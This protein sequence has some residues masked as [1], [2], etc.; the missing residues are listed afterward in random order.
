M[1]LSS[2]PTSRI[3]CVRGWLWIAACCGVSVA[4]GETIAL[5]SEDVTFFE[6]K[7]RPIFVAHCA[8][9]HSRMTGETEGGLSF[10]SKADFL[11][12]EGVA[13]AGRPDESLIVK[14]L[15]YDGDPQMPPDGKLPAAA[16]A[17]IEEW[18]RRGLPWPDDGKAAGPVE[19]FD[20]ASRKAAHWC[21]R[22]PMVV[23]TPK[24]EDAQWCRSDIDRFVLARLEAAGIEPAAEASLAVLVRRASEVLTGLPA[25]PADA[26]QVASHP[27]PLAF[28]AFV[29]RLLASPHYGERFARHWLD[30]VRYGETR[31]HE[32]DFLIP[33]VWRYRDWVVEAFNDDLPYDQFVREQIAG[34]LIQDPRID[35]GSG[36]N[37]SVVGT[38]FWFL[39]EEIHSPVDIAQD[40][41]DRIDNKVDTFGK[42]FLGLALGCAR[43]H[44]HKFDAI[45]NEDY[46]AIAGMLMSSSYRQVPLETIALNRRV[47]TQ[48]DAAD[49]D[50]RQKL[51]P[52]VADVI[53]AH[54]D[55]WMQKMPAVAEVVAAWREMDAAATSPAAATPLAG[56]TPLAAQQ[57][58]QEIVLADY[59]RGKNAT[60]VISDSTAWG[61]AARPPG[62]PRLSAATDAAPP[63]ITL[64]ALGAAFSDA[65]WSKSSSTGEREPGSQGAIDRAGRLLRTPKVRITN[66]VL[67]HRVRGHLQIVAVV[68]GHVMVHGPLYGATIKTVDTKGQWEWIQHDL[69]H[70][71]AWDASASQNG[72]VVHVEF[73]AISGEAEVAEVVAAEQQPR[74]VDPLVHFLAQRVGVF[75]SASGDGPVAESQA[76][77]YVQQAA[78][79]LFDMTLQACRSGTLA[80]APD[81]AAMASLVARLLPSSADAIPAAT[82]IAG[83]PRERLLKTAVG[84]V[85]GRNQIAAAATMVS[86]T[87]PA[88]LDGNGI[89]QH[90]LLKGSASR[91][92][93]RVPRR[94]LEAIDGLSQQPW[95]EHSSGRLELADRVLDAA[96][97]LASR[98]IVNRIWHH[99][100][101]RGLVATPDNFGKLGEQ[102]SDTTSQA[103]LDSLAVRFRAEG[104][105]I[106]RLVKEIV[107]SS[108]WRMSSR[109][110]PR[111]AAQ[112]PLNLLLHHYPL[113]RLE[114]EAIHDKILALSGRLDRTIGGPS[115]EVFLTEAHDGRGK[116]P[117]GPLDGGG[118]RSIYTKIRRNFLPSF[119]VA[120]DLPTPFQA[121]GMRNVTN[122]PAQS[123]SLMNDPFVNQQATLWAKKW[124]NDET[125]TTHDRIDRMYRDAFA[126]PPRSD[127]EA[128]AVEFLAA[129]A[130]QHGGTIAAQPWQLAA[131]SDFAHAMI[132]AKEFIFIP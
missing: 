10:D 62:Q 106:K 79:E 73:A 69:R 22:A 90:V 120:F 25:D 84:L 34:D 50:M 44:D 81:A 118:R 6:S 13:V 47:A 95:P 5:R 28:D 122:V 71:R 110:D 39:G 35:P 97:P 27:D 101:G 41:A 85:A 21:W 54:E 86:A 100:F 123:L 78:R 93:E 64:Q 32:S 70:D 129:Q 37:Q 58:G 48:L 96:N 3:T 12:A 83:S 46:Y 42:A 80:D 59:T 119:L 63:A 128:A 40:E 17:T 19:A 91:P 26:E 74:R 82:V 7:V 77:Q 92:G 20:I 56:A 111:A 33:N 72:H 125:L 67:W 1:A 102:P 109:R 65:V 113:R 116:P 11:T 117:S 121:M 30:V 24:V 2:V 114:A 53:A 31:G 126:R 98:V 15:R 51:L 112:D 68:D 94:F 89:D 49:A 66:G 60:A 52:L 29:D 18:V 76:R 43:C 108:T 8:K 131:W 55:V 16:I 23:P 61:L 75:A 104:W 36:A 4:S 103:I 14:V 107:T 45:S 127:E 130:Q 88:I 38:G 132:N 105:S 115:V 57:A 87:A 124:L 9:C 99:L